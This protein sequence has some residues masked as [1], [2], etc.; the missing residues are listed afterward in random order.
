MT[1]KRIAWPVLALLTFAVPASAQLAQA[2]ASSLGL[3]FNMTASARGFA[4]IAN[5]PA[6]L[7]HDET[8]F[9]SLAIPAVTGVAGVGPITL[10]ELAEYEGV[11]LPDAV[12]AD[13]LARTNTANGQSGSVD[14]G[15]TPFALQVGSIGFQLSTVAAVAANFSA[16]AIELYL[17]GNAGRTGSAED[18]NLDDSMLD[19]FVL[20][21]GALSFGTKVAPGIHAGA[22]AKYT[23]G[24]GIA[25]G[26][27][28]GTTFTSDPLEVQVD[29][30]MIIPG[31]ED[32]GLN[33][34]SGFGLDVGVVLD[35]PGLTIGATIQNIV[36]T[37]EW[38]PE[39]LRYVPGQALFN[40][41]G[42]DADFDE[43]PATEAPAMLLEQLAEATIKP[44]F[45]A[46]VQ[47]QPNDRLKVTADLRKR[48]EGGMALGPSFHA[49]VGAEVSVLSMLPVRGHLAKV[50]GGI[51]VGGGA[52]LVLGPVNV[53]GGGALRTST[54]ENMVL[55][56]FTLSFGAR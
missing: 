36:N 13:W 41:D 48:V 35:Q 34:G 23:V 45:S 39:G 44:V 9:F 30:P 29:F 5:N 16:D 43:R 8:G 32:A 17:Y 21:T 20:T 51:Q 19:G 27:S 25:M 46:G 2:S 47:L 49:G 56:A 54:D 1:I 31:D 22:T 37:F 6:G 55:G 52:S 10:A 38:D 33:N 14:L 24:H 7:G 40:I 15:V 11:R 53:T 18:F 26:R 4:A 12:A 50:S 28:Q 3:G 42:G